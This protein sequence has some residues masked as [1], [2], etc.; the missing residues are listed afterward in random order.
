MPTR[1]L[2]P[3]VRDSESIEA[4]S[5]HAEILYYRLIVTVD[6]FGRYDARPSMV[7]AACFPIRESMTG[8]KVDSL[9]KE[10]SDHGLI[11]VY[12]VDGKPYIQMCKWDNIPRAK[13]S[14]YP[15]HENDCTQMYASV[16]N[17]NTDAPLTVTVTKTETKTETV[18]APSG[19]SD[20]VW[21]DFVKHRKAKKLQVTQT[22]IDGI[23]R[24]AKKAGWMLESALAECVI[25][26]WQSF[27]ADWVKD[28]ELSKTGQTNQSVMSGLTRGLVGGGQNVG[29]LGN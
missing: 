5:A 7:K 19:V 20:S 25:R 4:L 9:L 29:L 26:G 24:E 11:V 22:V 1:Y 14:K 3:G 12:Q 13:E 10:L 16:C 15:S 28:K 21:Q 23:Q 27:K 8:S 18:V 6:D 2:K 17:T